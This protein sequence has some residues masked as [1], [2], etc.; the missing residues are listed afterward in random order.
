MNEDRI[1]KE[2]D[3]IQTFHHSDMYDMIIETCLEERQVNF[4]L[5]V[6]L[7]KRAQTE[8]ALVCI[9]L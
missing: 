5:I 1:Q 6:T 9:I 7:R 2:L 8:Y 3:L 4:K